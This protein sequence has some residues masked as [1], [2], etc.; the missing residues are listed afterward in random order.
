MIRRKPKIIF[1]K[2]GF[3]NFG[4]FYDYKE[5]QFSKDNVKNVTLIS[6]EIGSGKTSIF[7]LF[8]W[9]L[10][11]EEH[12]KDKKSEIKFL[13]TKEII[14]VVNEFAIKQSRINDII[15]MKGLI[16]FTWISSSGNSVTYNVSRERSYKKIK[17]LDNSDLS[18]DKEVKKDEILEFIQNSDKVLIT[19][20]GNP[21]DFSEYDQLIKEM[22]PKAIRNFAFIHGEG[23]TRIL[24]IGNVGQLKKSVLAIS[25][26]PKIMGLKLY[27]DA[28]KDYFGKKR[29]DCFRDDKSLMQKADQIEKARKNLKK[30]S[31][32][33][34]EKQNQQQQ[35]N[36]KILEIDNEWGLLNQN[37]D[38]IENYKKILDELNNLRI[39]KFGRKGKKRVKGL[40]EERS[41]KLR[42]YAPVIYLENEI[43]LCLLDI[44]EKRQL[45]IIPGTSIP[46]R[47]LK[48]IVSRHDSCICETPWNHK[49]HKTINELIKTAK[50]HTY[51]ET[52]NKFE[53]HLERYSQTVIEGKRE[54]YRIQKELL[55]VNDDIHRIKEEKSR[56][57]RTLTEEQKTEDSFKK[58]SILHKD[59]DHYNKQLGQIEER[60]KQIENKIE[61][62]EK[63]IRDLDIEYSKLE[64]EKGKKKGEK[65]VLYYK[66]IYAKLN[67][68][69]DL[70]K[71]LAEIIG[72]RIREETRTET[73]HILIQLIKNP[74]QWKNV[75]IT[76]KSA[77]WEIN[78]KFGD[79]II[80]NISTG[81]TNILGLSF[82][83][84]LSNILGV[85]LPLIFDSPFGNLDAET[86]ELISENLPPI[87]KGRQII[88]LEKK[89][90]LTGSRNED[91]S[92][93]ELYS[94]LK[95]FIDYEY[96]LQNQ[97]FINAQI[98]EGD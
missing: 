80:T 72:D 37:R 98:I 2:M 60:I 64:T 93:R 5:I 27:L 78:A 69:D 12:E 70:R 51:F 28:A 77:G 4:P 79:T 3:E 13:R 91:G 63:H 21:I 97:T 88:F 65:D 30:L 34:I 54:L 50:K 6:G 47:Y 83:F 56:Y 45:G 20:G 29:K 1:E 32:D 41:E 7:Q 96:H 38:Y 35:Y 17:D 74:D 53:A 48:I 86:R 81:M 33:L 19:K 92:L 61:D 25:D 36:D 44:R 8:W 82:I 46:E 76:N 49:M 66:N 11:P 31:N 85:D 62:E 42:R 9:V 26:Y 10:F 58:L 16:E 68:V 87:F 95:K 90:N 94:E 67:D 43:N 14:N 59:R 40:I 73:E 89:V 39:R 18:T 71:K 15:T 24:S 84:A 57:E 52:I 75:T 23:M 55:D 22:F